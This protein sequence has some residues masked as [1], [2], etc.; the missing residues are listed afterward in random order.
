MKHIAALRELIEFTVSF[1]E[2][3]WIYFITYFKMK[4]LQIFKEKQIEICQLAKDCEYNTKHFDDHG[5]DEE[6]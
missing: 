2:I 6:I 4:Q 5:G 1:E 3:K